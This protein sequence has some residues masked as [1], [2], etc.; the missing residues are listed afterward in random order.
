LGVGKALSNECIRLAKID[1]NNQVILHTT[2][3]MEVAWSLY[4]KLGFERSTDLD[5]SQEELPVFGFR[6]RLDD[7]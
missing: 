7:G 3:A 2:Q 6:L 1:G 4:T 5:F